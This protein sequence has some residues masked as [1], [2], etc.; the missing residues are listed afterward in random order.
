MS[1]GPGLLLALPLE[2]IAVRLAVALGVA[3]LLLRILTRRDLR[4]PRARTVL[5]VSPFLVVGAVVVLSSRDL[6]LPALLR[7]TEH[8]GSLALP[9]ADRYLDFAPTAPVLVGL[10]ALVLA[11]LV[12]ARLARSVA[13]RRRVLAGARPIEPRF[14]ALVVRIAR[15]MAITPP[16]VLGVDGTIAGA[17]V[18]GV[19]DPVLLLDRRVLAVLDEVELEGVVA[20]ELAHVARRDNLVA[21]AVAI[22][23]DAVSFVPGAGWAERALHREREAAADQDA[24]AVTGRPAALASGLL[25]VLE[26]GGPSRSMPQGCAALMP[27][28]S[29]IDR[30]GVLLSDDRATPRRHH[31]E[32][33][34]AAA[35]GLIAVASAVVIPALLAGSDGEREALGILVAPNAPAATGDVAPVTEGRVFDVY[36]S[37]TSRGDMP[38]TGAV[39]VGVR[40]IDLLGAE[41]RPGAA[42]ACAAGSTLCPTA[43]T[44]SGLALRPAPIVLLEDRVTARWQATPLLDGRTGDGFGVYWLARIPTPPVPS[45]G[46]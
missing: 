30:V 28:S 45:T 6:A 2:S 46:R 8:A 7:P 29:V 20:H 17:A 10:W 33:V 16:R 4:S 12:S 37:A 21:W 14:A 3:L 24:V 18:I 35:V 43:G 15:A 31:L 11:V 1:M 13:F 9:V 41:D 38:G 5:A 36:R 27:S 26:L 25:R 32:L 39:R 22:V 40:P 44:S 42:A 34:L 23:R 19:R